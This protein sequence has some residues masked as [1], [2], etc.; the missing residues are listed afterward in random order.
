MNDSDA[1]IASRPVA[2]RGRVGESREEARQKRQR[3]TNIEHR[4]Q[5]N[6]VRRHG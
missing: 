1:A 5:N 2:E 6:E 4:T 3:I